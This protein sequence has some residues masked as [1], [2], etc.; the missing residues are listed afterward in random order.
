MKIHI[1]GDPDG[2]QGQVQTL[3]P[4]VLSGEKKFDQDSVDVVN[5]AGDLLRRLTAL[6]ERVPLRAVLLGRGYLPA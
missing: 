3:R 6:H 5:D 4:M 2:A 1:A